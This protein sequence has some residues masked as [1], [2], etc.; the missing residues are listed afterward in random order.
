M[1]FNGLTR[2]GRFIRFIAIFTI[3]LFSIGE[4]YPAYAQPLS[5]QNAEATSSSPYPAS[6]HA[7]LIANHLSVPEALGTIQDVFIPT[8]N[9]Q[10]K[11]VIH[12]QSA[13]ANYDAES[14]AQKIIKYLQTEYGLRL[15]FLEGGEGAL[16]SLFFRSFPDEELKLSVLEEYLRRGD[17]SGGEIAAILD[18]T[19]G[20]LFLGVEDQALYE[21]NKKAFLQVLDDEV[22][23]KEWIEALQN[24]L[25]GLVKDKLSAPSQLFYRTQR[26]FQKN[27]LGLLDYLKA[28]IATFLLSI[29]PRQRSKFM[30]LIRSLLRF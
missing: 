23:N 19:F 15:I 6:A 8:K 14:N 26:Q 27:E 17:L 24:R 1:A 25:E 18:E 22:K 5:I 28:L 7:T 10:N 9:S 4:V 13:H 12:L 21:E 3:C 20:S 30:R 29:Y 11:I 2:K 16:D